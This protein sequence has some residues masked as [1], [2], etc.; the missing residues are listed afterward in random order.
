MQGAKP[1]RE[2]GSSRRKS[3]CRFK[4][5]GWRHAKQGFVDDPARHLL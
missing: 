1:T 4:R 2:P 5:L 3:S